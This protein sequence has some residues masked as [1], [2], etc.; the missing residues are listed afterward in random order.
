MPLRRGFKSE[1]NEIVRESRA[2]LGLGPVD[3]LNPWLFADYLGV[4]VV[5]MTNLVDVAGSAVTYFSEVD[6]SSFS[7][8]TVFRGSHRMIV[9]NDSHVPGRQKSDVSHELSHALL[10]HPPS[11][12]IYDR[13][14]RVWNQ[15]I[16]GKR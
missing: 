12:A 6:P 9:H 13:G 1:T 4:P 2:E 3:P 14:C 5:A 16:L 15:E 11:P 8:V 7:A 10:L